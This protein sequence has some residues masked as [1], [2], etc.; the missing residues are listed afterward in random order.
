MGIEFDDKGFVKG[1]TTPLVVGDNPGIPIISPIASYSWQYGLNYTNLLDEAVA[2]IRKL[3]G[4]VKTSADKAR[5]LEIEIEILQ[6]LQKEMATKP[7]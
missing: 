5:L 2:V 3:R 7:E 4:M 6:M 1:V